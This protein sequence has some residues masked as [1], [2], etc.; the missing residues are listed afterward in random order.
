MKHVLACLAML[1]AFNVTAQVVYP[2]NPDANGDSVITSLDLLDFLPVFA[3]SFTPNAIS[4]NGISLDSLLNNILNSINEQETLIQQLQQKIDSLES[5][6]QLVTASF[7]SW[8]FECS[9]FG[10][11][12]QCNISDFTDY[13]DDYL[14]GLNPAGISWREFTI[15]GEGVESVE[16]IGLRY[17]TPKYDG[18]CYEDFHFEPKFWQTSDLGQTSGAIRWNIAYRRIQYSYSLSEYFVTGCGELPELEGD[19]LVFTHNSSASCGFY[20]NLVKNIEVLVKINGAWRL[21]GFVY[22]V[23]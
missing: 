16:A 10:T 15:S 1:A 23:E 8:N 2:Y 5:Q 19:V 20:N 4:I 21:T 7:E 6:E 22:E 13:S 17:W 3:S 18:G 11:G 12:D 9:A 14:Y